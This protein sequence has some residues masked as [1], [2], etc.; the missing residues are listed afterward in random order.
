MK[1]LNKTII[2]LFLLLVPIVIYSCKTTST[3]EP[4][5]EQI[6]G[7]RDYTWTVDTL[8]TLYSHLYSA[9]GLSP[10]DIWAVGH[11]MGIEN[12]L[13]HYDGIKWT[14]GDLKPCGWIFPNSIHGF[15]KNNI[16]IAGDEGKILHYD[17]NTWK[18]FFTYFPPEYRMSYFH[19]V[20]GDSPDN[21]YAVGTYDSLENNLDNFYG[22]ILHYNGKEWQRVNIIKN[23]CQYIRIS[24]DNKEGNRYYIFGDNMNYRTG[25]DTGKILEFSDG[26]IKELQSVLSS[27]NTN[28]SMKLINDKIYF[29]INSNLCRYINNQFQ[30]IKKIEGSSNKYLK[31]GRNENDLFFSTS[32]G[33]AHYNGTDFQLIYKKPGSSVIN[34]TLIFENEIFIFAVEMQVRSYI[35]KGILKK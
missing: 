8:E 31:G 16:W 22:L 13:W 28:L 10:D 24:K 21:V 7:R 34:E 3:T 27:V 12:F 23:N 35:I 15:S 29:V 19:S 6:P 11:G 5:E 25:S 2:R 14:R 20:W 30:V 17:G 9:W 1:Q 18:P 32:E 26:K 33:L 4:T